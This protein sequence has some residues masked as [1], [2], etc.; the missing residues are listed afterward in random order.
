MD[1]HLHTPASADWQE[2]N[3]TY[4]DWLQKCEARGLDI[5]AIA[6]HNTVAGIAQL[7]QDIERLG[8]LEEQGRL[9]PQEKQPRS[10]FTSSAFF[11]QR[12]RSV[13]WNYCSC[14]SMCRQLSWMLA[15]PR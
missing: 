13:N 15:Q 14:A 8:W 10:A 3:T 4:L 7:R 9:R 6:D 11:R 1:M 2:P 5:V 12:L